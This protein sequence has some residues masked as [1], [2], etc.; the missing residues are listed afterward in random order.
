TP[1]LESGHCRHLQHCIL[2]EFADNYLAFLKYVCFIDGVYT[3]ACC[4]DSRYPNSV[5]T[6]TYTIGTTTTPRAT[7]ALS[8]RGCG[9]NAKDGF[10]KRIV[11]GKPADPQEWPW[12]AALLLD[13]HEQNCGGVLY[14]RSHVLTAAHCVKPLIASE[15]TVRLGEY[16]FD[17][18]KDSLH[19]DFEVKSVQMHHLY[20][21]ET[22]ENDI[23]ILSLKGSVETFNDFIWPVCLPP[24]D[25][26]KYVNEKATVTGWGTIYHGGP[27]SKTLQEV[28]LPIWTNAECA[29]AYDGTDI[30]DNFLCAG[31]KVVGGRDAC[32]G[33]SGGPLQWK[34]SNGR[35]AV[36][37]VVSW[38]IKCAEPGNPGVYTRVNN[39]MD[40]IKDNSI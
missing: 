27:K 1:K 40:W 34:G 33:D 18:K 32:Q 35:W 23:A 5:T 39:Y 21:Y 14:T 19:R 7:T 17:Q 16:T 3:G 30:G 10:G 36:I 29:D 38:G 25:G 22:Y 9:L 13:G 24:A 20:N 28:T 2:P 31:I 26:Y 4:P 8:Q 6:S 12:M 11:G 15:I 37:G